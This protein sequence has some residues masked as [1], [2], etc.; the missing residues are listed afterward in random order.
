[1]AGEDRLPVFWRL[2]YDEEHLPVGVDTDSSELEGGKLRPQVRADPV[3]EL[4]GLDTASHAARAAL[5]RAD[6]QHGVA[7]EVAHSLFWAPIRRPEK[8]LGDLRRTC[9][10]SRVESALDFQ[11]IRF[12]LVANGKHTIQDAPQC[13]LTEIRD[14]PGPV[15]G[16]IE[17]KDGPHA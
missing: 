6:Y 2:R 16:G 15:R 13:A 9:S 7:V 17:Y 12:G 5:L 10:A 14:T 11:V 1:M 3:F 8:E 4:V